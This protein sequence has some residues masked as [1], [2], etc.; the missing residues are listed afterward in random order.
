M[1]RLAPL[2]VVIC[3]A[4]CSQASP[5]ASLISASPVNATAPAKFVIIFMENHSASEVIGNANMPYLN[6]FA[7]RGVRFTDFHE[8]NS[9]GPSLPDYLQLAAGSSCGMTT[10]A[11]TAGDPT[12]SSHCPTT[13]WN[14][15]QAKGISWGVYMDG[16]P[17]ACYGGSTYNNT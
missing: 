17:S 1:R 7:T 15:L 5:S 9:T 14:Q 16:M 13:L 10:D 12:V 8:G 2:A 4:A 6:S 11:V 3:L